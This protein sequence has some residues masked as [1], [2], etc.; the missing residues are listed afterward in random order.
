MGSKTFTVYFHSIEKLVGEEQTIIA[1]KELRA[2]LESI[3]ELALDKNVSLGRFYDDGKDERC[4][5]FQSDINDIPEPKNKDYLPGLFIKRR[6]SGYPYENDDKG[7]LLQIKLADDKNELAEVT[8]FVIDMSLCTLLFV[9]SLYVGS[10]TTFEDYLN[11]R[12][13][14]S[15]KE[16]IQQES[17]D[18][19]MESRIVL[20]FIIN[21]NPE[22]DFNLMTN[23]S[24]LELRIAGSL[25]LLESSLDNDKSSSAQTMKRL[26]KFAGN[27]RSKSI[28][29]IFS[30][31]HQQ[32]EKLDKKEISNLYKKLKKFFNQSAN[33]NKFMVKGIIDE[34]TR[35]IDLLN[36]RYFHRCSLDYDGR[37]L[38]LANVFGELYAMMDKYHAIFIR[39][40]LFQ[41][42]KS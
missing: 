25:K 39:E 22:K 5:I 40:N 21:E 29:V 13:R 15:A 31:G 36:D 9:N 10:S 14:K 38:P 2:A 26:A 24:T 19:D 30:S 37:Y 42:D 7:N 17:S 20:P 35:Y 3:R 32:K 33:N 27:S 6:A 41:E 16:A 4:L 34:E 23:I 28:K 12:I 1:K 18:S 11:N 8:Y